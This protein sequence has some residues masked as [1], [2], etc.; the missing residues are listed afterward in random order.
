MSWKTKSWIIMLA[1]MV[2]FFLTGLCIGWLLGVESN[3]V[4]VQ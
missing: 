3:W 1:L 4:I 2:A